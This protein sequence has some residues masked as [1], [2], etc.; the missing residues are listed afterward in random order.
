LGEE[1]LARVESPPYPLDRAVGKISPP[2]LAVIA[3]R[4]K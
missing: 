1:G 2:M 3:A 4:D